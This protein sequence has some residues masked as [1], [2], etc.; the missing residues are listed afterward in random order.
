MRSAAQRAAACFA[1]LIHRFLPPEQESRHETVLAIAHASDSRAECAGDAMIDLRL[2]RASPESVDRGLERRGMEPAA[3]ELLEIDARHRYAVEELGNLQAERNALSKQAGKAQKSGDSETFA[4]LREKAA[5]L[6]DEI[7]K[8]QKHAEEIN[9]SLTARLSELPNLPADDV[10][11][12]ASEEDNAMLKTV[13]D[14][15]PQSGKPHYEIGEALGLMDFETAAKLA[16]ARYV[17][18]RGALARLHQALGRLML[19]T[20][21]DKNCYEETWVPWLVLPDIP[22]GTGQLPKFSEDLYETTRGQW[23]IPTAEVPLTNLVRER[24]LDEESLPLRFVAWTPCFRAE[25]GAAG[26]DTRGMLRQ[27]QFEKV[28]LVSVTSPEASEAEHE[29]MTACAE[30]ILETL[31]LPYRRVALCTGDLGF[32]AT[33]TYDLEVWLP[34]QGR[35]REI[36]SCSNCGD[37]QARRMNA[38]YRPEAG[39][40]KTQFVHT[41]NGSGLA[42][43]RALIAVME[44]GQTEDGGIDLPE[45]LSPYMGG[46]HRIGPDG[47]LV[48]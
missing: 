16:G 43:G 42:V 7:Q 5:G 48:Q 13:G 33:K 30:G 24:I 12:G 45:A 10:P 46:A 3:E 36:S 31:G 11:D 26:Q 34:G 2:L 9:E 39:D 18:L 37:F 44:N 41:L 27:H 22:Y 40:K 32:S 1:S 19:D 29:R 20:H 4:N 28:E 17:V 25:A 14:P 23:L 35:Y 6:R 38:R 21:V 47:V 15:S 8:R